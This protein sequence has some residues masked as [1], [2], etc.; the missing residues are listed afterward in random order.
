MHAQRDILFEDLCPFALVDARHLEDLSRVEVTV[1]PSTHH[2]DSSD[3]HLV[4]WH[5][6]VDGE[7]ESGEDR[8]ETGRDAARV[9]GCDAKVPNSTPERVRT[10]CKGCLGHWEV[11]I[12]QERR[13]RV[14]VLRVRPS[15]HA[16]ARV[17]SP[18]VL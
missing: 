11:G 12:R 2:S 5:G 10:R 8:A 3:H 16:Y 18:P 9:S 17:V 15:L 4:H 1:G 7:A 13:Q 14:M 6:R